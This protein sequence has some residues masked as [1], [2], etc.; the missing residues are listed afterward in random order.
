M[1]HLPFIEIDGEPYARWW[2]DRFDPVNDPFLRMRFYQRGRAKIWVGTA[3]IANLRSTRTDAVGIHLLRIGGRFWKPTSAGIVA[4]GGS[5]R[6]SV[7]DLDRHETVKFLAGEDVRLAKD[8]VRREVLPRGFIAVRY[9]CVA[10]GCAEWHGGEVV[11]SLIPK[12]RR[13]T[14]I[15]L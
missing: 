3:G 12:N 7:I 13:I 4:F 9:H 8:D 15:D 6:A 14:K 2:R 5:A 11:T 10:I 1:K